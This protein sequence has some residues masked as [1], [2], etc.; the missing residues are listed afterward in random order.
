MTS[1]EEAAYIKPESGLCSVVS[2]CP[3]GS[4]KVVTAL[5]LL[6]TKWTIYLYI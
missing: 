4:L 3:M 2:H 5:K 6:L 1:L